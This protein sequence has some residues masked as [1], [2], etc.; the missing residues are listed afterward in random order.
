MATCHSLTFIGGE[1]TGDPL[2]MVMFEATQW[3]T[4]REC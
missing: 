1:L 3:V 4:W 2:D